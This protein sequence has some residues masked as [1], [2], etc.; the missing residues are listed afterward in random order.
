MEIIDERK[1][2]NNIYEIVP[3][4]L[5]NQNEFADE[6]TSCF[7]NYE[8]FMRFIIIKQFLSKQIKDEHVC[9]NFT[10][11]FIIIYIKKIII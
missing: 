1:S 9:I 11:L 3:I 6:I 8:F 4:V 2:F 5:N 7:R 10:A